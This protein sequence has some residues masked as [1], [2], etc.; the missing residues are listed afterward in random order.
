M[1]NRLATIKVAKALGELCDE[2]VFVGG[3][4]VS[5][6]IDDP[7]AE[8]IR[9]TKDIDLTFQ[10]S[11]AGELDSVRTLLNLKGFTEAVDSGVICRFNYEDLLVDVMSTKEVGW[12]PSN[13][14]FQKG[15]NLAIAVI[16]EDIEIKI[17]PLP[18][19]L[20]TKFD[21]F[22]DRGAADVYASK[23]L[24]DLV[25]LFNHT[26]TIIDQVSEAPKDVQLYL[27]D[28]V[29]QLMNDATAMGAIPG[30]LFY[31]NAEE[32]YQEIKQKFNELIS[33]LQRTQ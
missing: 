20:A 15:F 33:V 25:Y 6:Y 29:A 22:F 18:Y 9:P 28:A 17:L 31:E 2:V 4:M 32:Q 23:D 10:I 5:L 3:A 16:L 12:A 19:F 21:A 27:K 24:E 1:I 14:W 26:S 7:Y 8:D 11:T 13:R 30:H